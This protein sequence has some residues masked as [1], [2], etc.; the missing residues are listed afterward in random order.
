MIKYFILGLSLS[1]GFALSLHSQT[2]STLAGRQ[3][4]G[5]G[6]YT[7]IRGNLKDSVWFSAPYGIELDTA[8]RIY[9][10]NEHNVFCIT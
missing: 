1:L 9:L 8:G 5:N 7:G 4:I 10:T 6:N 2:V 3:Y